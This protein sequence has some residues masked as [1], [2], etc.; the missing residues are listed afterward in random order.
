L[1]ISLATGRKSRRS[2]RKVRS[3][4]QN[5]RKCAEKELVDSH[6]PHSA[7]REEHKCSVVQGM[8]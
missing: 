7:T 4:K 3:A 8:R 6:W 5:E 2:T 1:I